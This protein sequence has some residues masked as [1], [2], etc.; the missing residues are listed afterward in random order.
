M[1][2]TVDGTF[3]GENMKELLNVGDMDIICEFL[4]E[5]NKSLSNDRRRRILN[6]LYREEHPVTF[7]DIKSNVLDKN[8]NEMSTGS[9][10]NHLEKLT[11]SN[12]VHREGKKPVRYSLTKFIRRLV[13]LVNFY[14]MQKTVKASA[15]ADIDPMSLPEG[16]S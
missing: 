6:Y 9:L 1:K 3:K 8:Q 2:S 10:H 12:F 7:K 5:I 13:Y 15:K 16:L 14:E 4:D 11:G